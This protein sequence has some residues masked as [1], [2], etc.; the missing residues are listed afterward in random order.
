MIAVLR[1]RIR[2]F[3]RVSGSNKNFDNWLVHELALKNFFLFELY[4]VF[5]MILK[6][7][8]SLRIIIIVFIFVCYESRK[9]VDPR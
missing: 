6:I 3:L 4:K 8:N 2:P 9:E 7:F 1:I 5:V